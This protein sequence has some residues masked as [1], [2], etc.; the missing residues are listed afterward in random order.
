METTQ[1]L[2]NNTLEEEIAADVKPKIKPYSENAALKRAQQRYYEKNKEEK[3]KHNKEYLQTW[4]SSKDI[5]ELRAKRRESCKRYYNKK[6]LLKESK[7]EQEPRT[8][9]D[10]KIALYMDLFDEIFDTNP[11][12]RIEIVNGRLTF[13]QSS[14]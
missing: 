12:N 2:S 3:L 4:I 5:E 14:E 10:D 13:P 9:E 7:Q 11:R 1:D 8:S 6:K